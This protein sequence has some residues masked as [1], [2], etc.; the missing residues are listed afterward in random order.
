MGGLTSRSNP[1]FFNAI[2]SRKNIEA[3]RAQYV[4]LTEV[5]FAIAT[6]P[7]YKNS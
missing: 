6:Q 3:L 1:L 2:L 7:Q 4:I 5:E